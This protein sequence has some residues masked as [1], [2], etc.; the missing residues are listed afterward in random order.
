MGDVIVGVIVNWMSSCRLAQRKIANAYTGVSEVDIIINNIIIIII[1]YTYI[2]RQTIKL[3]LMCS[4]LIL[5][6]QECF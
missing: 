1:L 5:M 4:M 6:E 2:A 3:S